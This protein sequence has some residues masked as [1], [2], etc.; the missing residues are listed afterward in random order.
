MSAAIE[1]L[2]PERRAGILAGAATVFTEDG[3]EG[4]SMSRIAREAG[5]SKGTLY[6]YFDS[7]AAL[8][9]A[10]V[11]QQCT[12]KLRRIFDG[13]EPDG[14]PAATLRGIGLRMMRMMLSELGIATYRVVVSEALKFPELAQIFYEAGPARSIQHLADWITEQARSGRL[15]VED[16]PFAAE[17]FFAL[18]QTRLAMRCRL[19]LGACN[20]D[21]EIE[22]VVDAAVA[23]FLARYGVR[24]A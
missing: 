17:Q 1:A 19:R 9:A 15:Q 18:T 20:D 16:A 7:K 23:M 4:A 8:F 5:V 24:C 2:T 11:E 22:R 21:A 6:N 12:E 10:F 14:D 13:A 3:Y